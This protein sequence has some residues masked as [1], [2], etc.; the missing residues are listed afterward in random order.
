MSE[1]IAC[2][3]VIINNLSWSRID[4]IQ[5]L[6]R[7]SADLVQI[8]ILVNL[9][10]QRILFAEQ[11]F[12]LGLQAGDLRR[13]IMQLHCSLEI[14]KPRC[15]DEDQRRHNNDRKLPVKL[16]KLRDIVPDGSLLLRV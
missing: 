14:H 8:D 15:H 3:A 7:K 4:H 9:C 1:I 2:T 12:P 6:L 10:L 13:Q 11:V 16:F 5:F